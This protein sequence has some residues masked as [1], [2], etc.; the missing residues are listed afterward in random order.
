MIGNR[1]KHYSLKETSRSAPEPRL[2]AFSDDLGS[3]KY[4]PNLAQ[5]ESKLAHLYNRFLVT[6]SKKVLER[7]KKTT[8]QNCQGYSS[9]FVA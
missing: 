5:I 7:K 9:D 8:K 2:N 1:W 3:W 6:R 4:F